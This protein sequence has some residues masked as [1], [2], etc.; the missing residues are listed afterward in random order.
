[1]AFHHLQVCDDA[2][3]IRAISGQIT[4]RW[5]YERLVNMTYSPRTKV[6]CIWRRQDDQVHMHK[7]YTKKCRHLYTCMKTAMERAAQRGKV[8]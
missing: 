1:M 8:G 7:F 2:V 4:E 3:I 6:L 5:W